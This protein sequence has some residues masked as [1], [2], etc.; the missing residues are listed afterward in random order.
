MNTNKGKAVFFVQ[1]RNIVHQPG[2]WRM[3]SYTIIT[4]SHVVNIIVAGSTIRRRLVK[5]QGSMAFF[6]I[7]DEVNAFQP[8]TQRIVVVLEGINIDVP[9]IGIMACATIY[10]KRGTVWGLGLHPGN[11]QQEHNY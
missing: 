11:T 7:G 6:T 1:F 2:L 10:L 8:E 3:A 5:N 4:D 9:S